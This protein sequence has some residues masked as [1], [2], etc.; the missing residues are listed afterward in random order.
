MVK[1]VILGILAL[2]LIVV[3]ALCIVVAK[4]PEEFR[5]MR[6]AEINA[7]TDK[8]FE[9]VNDFHKWDSW[10]PWAKM[11]RNMKVTYS[12]P[13]SGVGAAYS[14]VGNDEVGEGKMTIRS[15][16]PPKQIVIDLEFIKP[17][18]AKNITGF[19]FKAE[20]EK[21]NIT[22]SMAGKKNFIMKAFCLVMDMDKTVGADFEKGLAKLK[23]VAE[24]TSVQ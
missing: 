7:P 20:G 6:S 11:D 2:V 16:H 8:V 13:D 24:S 15:N 14:W 1:K 5:V 21:T 12:G 18:A 3:G 17:F 22:W 19:D 9:F 4:Q 10:S 23:T